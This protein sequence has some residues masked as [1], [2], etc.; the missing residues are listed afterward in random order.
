MNT[1]DNNDDIL[2]FFQIPRDIVEHHEIFHD[3]DTL[4]IDI[5]LIRRIMKCPVC[6]TSTSVIASYVTKAITHSVVNGKKC[7]IRYHARRYTC[8]ACSKTFYEPN[9]F[10]FDGE[11]ISASTVYNVLQD[12]RNPNETYKSLSERYHISPTSVIKIFDTHAGTVTHALPRVLSIDEVYVPTSDSNRYLCILMDFETSKI[13]DVLPS[14]HKKDLVA[15]FSS[16]PREERIKVEL[17]SSDMWKTYHDVASFMLPACSTAVDRFH[18][19]QELSKQFTHVRV[20]VMNKYYTIRNAYLK[21]K[22]NCVLTPDEVV[23][24]N[25]ASSKYYALKKFSWLFFNTNSRIMDPNCRRRYNRVIRRYMNLYD[26]HDYMIHCDDEL[27][28]AADLKYLFEK[29]YKE[30]TLDNAKENL[31]N[32][33]YDFR[34]SGIA[35]MRH[36]AGTLASWKKEIINSFIT[37]GDR[38]INNGRIENINK[39]IKTLKRNANG[40]RNFERLKKR[41]IYCINNEGNLDVTMKKGN[42]K[43]ETRKKQSIQTAD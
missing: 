7:I 15:Y 16:I 18:V 22:K 21:K 14:R 17:V 20:R 36:F 9:P 38:R 24:L 28:R 32:L 31:E 4:I 19:L 33:I 23:I 37:V 41:I 1:A 3:G 30:C 42:R 26:I 34:E 43:N 29:F 12:L 27:E 13:V 5:R 25:E 11:R 39:T 40:F 8:P 35:E 2:E 6:G 10:S